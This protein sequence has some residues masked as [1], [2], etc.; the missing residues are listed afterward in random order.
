VVV[1]NC[2]RVFA[3]EGI[4]APFAR[5]R[6]HGLQVCV[7]TDGYGG[8]LLGDLSMAAMVSRLWANDPGATTAGDLIESVT[9]GAARAL[10][11]TDLGA[12]RAGAAGDLTVFDLTHPQ[13]APLRD[14]RRALLAYAGNARM[15]T[16]IVGGHTL[17]REGRWLGGDAAA[18]TAAGEAAV[19]RLW[20]LP[21]VAAAL[22]G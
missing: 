19:R 18:I 21:D 1:L 3:R 17:V 11:R 15:D 16:L 5:F 6:R 22:G 2:P 10:G 7:A 20:N 9:A 14:P 12:I 4:L 13:V 8:D